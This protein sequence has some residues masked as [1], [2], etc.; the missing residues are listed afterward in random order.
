[1]N[2]IWKYFRNTLLAALAGSFS[3]I[4]LLRYFDMRRKY[5]SSLSTRR[6][7]IIRTVSCQSIYSAVYQEVVLLLPDESYRPC[8][9]FHAGYH[10]YRLPLVVWIK[11]GS[12]GTG[13][14][15]YGKTCCSRQKLPVRKQPAY[16][17]RIS[18]ALMKDKHRV[19]S[20]HCDECW[21]LAIAC[22]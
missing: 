2:K 18:L 12:S 7:L 20:S 5:D 21:Q 19:S 9:T 3:R 1:M 22:I 6:S 16:V 14:K 15:F 10:R 11:A 17:G 8:Q 13:S 4:I